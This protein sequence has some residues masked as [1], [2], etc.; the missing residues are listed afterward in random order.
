M[1]QVSLPTLVFG[2]CKNVVTLKGG[3]NATMAPQIDYATHVFG[4]AASKM[5]VEF[6]INIEKRGYFP[7]GGGSLDLLVT[8]VKKLQPIILLE[9][10]NL[11]KTYIRSF[12]ARVDKSNA[13]TMFS[14]AQ[15]EIQKALPVSLP[16]ILKKII[17]IG[18]IPCFM[19]LSL[20]LWYS[21]LK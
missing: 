13:V 15:R 19:N 9:R 18:Y 2:G 12:V 20:Y 10:G 11:I 21:N 1:K 5:G 4:Q 17:I 14:T 3:T 8:P 7:K 16:P 6:T